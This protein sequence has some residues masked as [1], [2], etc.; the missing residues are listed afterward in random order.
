M[1][2]EET[3]KGYQDSGEGQMA[4]LKMLELVRPFEEACEREILNFAQHSK[5]RKTVCKLPFLDHSSTHEFCK[6]LSL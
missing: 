3:L 6:Y 5:G 2:V 1:G 4:F